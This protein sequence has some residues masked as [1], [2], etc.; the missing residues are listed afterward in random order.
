MT[1]PEPPTTVDEPGPTRPRRPRR[2]LAAAAVAVLAAV[3]IPAA[4]QVAGFSDVAAD[5]V[6]AD[7]IA[8]M[9]EAGVTAGCRDGRYCPGDAVT[10]GAMASFLGRA[11]SQVIFDR[12]AT[13][14][15]AGA[16]QVDGVP[17]SVSVT[18]PGVE[19]G[20]Q[21]VALQ[22][23]VTVLH[24]GELT[25]CPCEV[26]AFVFR[27]RDDAQG[28][29]SYT[30]LTGEVAGSHGAVS[31]PVSWATQLDAGRTDEFLV[32]VFVDGTTVGGV[33][34]EGTLTATTAPLG[35]VPQR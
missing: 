5:S 31:L 2:L 14:L 3:A 18:G 28:P 7:N 13:T 8:A 32:A 24:D 10:R 6:H 12:S 19:G 33:T 34:A 16:G 4:A 11:G 27:D 22:G 30:T 15:A 1:A 35:Q 17:V 25:D 23:S 21:H 20:T 26:E 29:S 9:S